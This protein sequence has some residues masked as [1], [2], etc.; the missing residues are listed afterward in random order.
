[1]RQ[2]LGLWVQYLSRQVQKVG[3][4]VELNKEATPELM[5]QLKPDVAIVASG[6]R[7]LL[8]AIPGVEG[9][10]VISSSTVLGGRIAILRGKVLVLGGGMVGCDIADM[11]AYRGDEQ[12]A[13]GVEV[14]VLEMLED[15]ALDMP[16]TS[17]M[18]LLPRL[19]EKA[20]R[21]ITS[22]TVKEITPDGVVITKD[23]REETIGGFDHIILACGTRSVDELSDEISDTV[24]EVFV[25]GD[26]K[27]PRG[28]LEAIAEGA[29]VA[30]A[31]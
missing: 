3:V 15:V 7:P 25:I 11:L 16:A 8:P 1:M 4:K 30:R 14:T 19:R 29:E 22:A 24:P 23:R 27:E 12:G 21:V 10:K 9:A 26:A 20:V 6:G 13:A 31:I 18:L 17:R 5:R 28:A 2:E